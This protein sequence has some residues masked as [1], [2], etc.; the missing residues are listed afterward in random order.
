MPATVRNPVREDGSRAPSAYWTKRVF[1]ELPAVSGAAIPYPTPCGSSGDNFAVFKEATA[2]PRAGSILGLRK[3]DYITVFCHGSFT[4]A[5]VDGIARTNFLNK[6]ASAS[7]KDQVQ[8]GVALGELRETAG[9]I[10]DLSLR[11]VRGVT[12]VAKKNVA[13]RSDHRPIPRHRVPLW[14][15][16]ECGPSRSHA[17]AEARLRVGRMADVPVRPSTPGNGCL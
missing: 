12:T 15:T 13:V 11:A 7:G 4:K 2:I 9:M 5:T 16:L 17:S 1:V 8:L 10:T 6:L 14:D 3:Q